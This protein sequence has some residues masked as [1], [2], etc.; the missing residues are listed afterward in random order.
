[1]AKEVENSVKAV[2]VREEQSGN[3]MVAGTAYKAVEQVTVPVLKHDSGETVAFEIVQPILAEDNFET[4]IDKKTGE[5]LSQ[6]FKGKINVG[7]VRELSSGQL[8]QY[9]FNAISASELRNAYPNDGYVGKSFAIKKLDLVA[10][11]RY[12]EVQIVEISAL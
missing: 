8:F 2:A 11:K 1:M 9:V 3:F 12:K 5:V 4:E 6:T 10:G 7:R